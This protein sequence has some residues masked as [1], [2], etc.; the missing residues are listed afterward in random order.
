MSNTF[1]HPVA[2]RLWIAALACTFFLPAGADA[3][4]LSWLGIDDEDPP[5]EKSEPAKE[6]PVVKRHA[7]EATPASTLADRRLARIVAQQIAVY[8]DLADKIGQPLNTEQEN[9]LAN[10][11]AMYDSFLTE[12]PDHLYGHILYGKFL[13]DIGQA[14]EA[15]AVFLRANQI[16]PNVA[17]VKQQIGNYF[18][19]TGD[20]IIAL[21][22]FLAATE[23]EPNEPMYHYQLGEL[24]YFYR[25]FLLADGAYSR[26]I[27]DQQMLTA[28]HR[29]AELAPNNS[30]YSFRYAE[31]F[32]DL[33]KPQWDN[34][35]KAWQRLANLEL[36]DRE[37][38]VAR[39]QTARVLIH[40]RH[41][42]EARA[43]I[44]TVSN[45]TL[46]TAR[47]ELLQSISAGN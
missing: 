1:L 38:D 13:R 6:E 46:Q 14:E 8:S 12:A 24:I 30:N 37:R 15:N 47:E 45:P 40:L 2:L 9:S 28:F 3:S 29:A 26:E 21:P 25:D 43:L 41:N 27:L 16:N 42:D 10:I 11:A 19:E 5:T 39:L 17:V 18:A 7:L 20:Y 23:L 33:K 44:E 31:S 22:Y 36:T 4:W 32:F 35:L 34:A